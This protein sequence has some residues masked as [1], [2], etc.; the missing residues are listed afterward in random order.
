VDLAARYYF[1]RYNKMLEVGGRTGGLT[2]G[3][4]ETNPHIQGTVVDLPATTT[5]TEHY[6]KDSDFADRVRVK[7]CD[8][9]E[10]TLEGS[11]DAVIMK[12]FI[13][14]LNPDQARRALANIQRVTEPGGSVYI[15]GAVLDDSRLSPLEAVGSSLN[16]LN[17]YDG[18]QS[19]TQAEYR[20]WL[21]EAGFD[22]VERVVVS[23]GSSIIAARKPDSADKS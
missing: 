1:S 18:G 22:V 7:A 6:V 19:Y 14:V 2:F 13:Q 12:S 17:I 8:V 15:L 11:Y 23:D 3:V 9:V 5:V 21:A 4:L 10:G 16:F 20:G